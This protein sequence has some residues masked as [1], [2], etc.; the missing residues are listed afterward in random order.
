MRSSGAIADLPGDHS[1][2]VHP[3][4]PAAHLPGLRQTPALE[5]APQNVRQ[6]LP[7]CGRGAQGARPLATA[8]KQRTLEVTDSSFQPGQGPGPHL[9][10]PTKYGHWKPLIKASNVLR[11]CSFDFRAHNDV[12]EATDSSL[13]NC[14]D[15]R[16]HRR[17][18]IR[19]PTRRAPKARQQIGDAHCAFLRWNQWRKK[20]G[21]PV[22]IYLI[23]NLV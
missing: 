21:I 1:H 11:F 22:R 16:L 10:P 8:H 12:F 17:E 15:S 9:L 20:A 13:K 7:L 19:R 4:A 5:L 6:L 3:E 23:L 14:I 2:P 18:A